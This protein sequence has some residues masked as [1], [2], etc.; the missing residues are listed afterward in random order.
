MDHAVWLRSPELHGPIGRHALMIE[1]APRRSTSRAGRVLAS[2]RGTTTT[3][4][5]KIHPHL[6]SGTIF[7]QELQGVDGPAP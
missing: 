2:R 6:Q 3:T 4:A 1:A 5:D 7:R